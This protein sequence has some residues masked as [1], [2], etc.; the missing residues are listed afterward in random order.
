[1]PHGR[2]TGERDCSHAPRAR[3]LRIAALVTRRRQAIDAKRATDDAGETYSF[4]R[5]LLATGGRPRRLPDAPDEVIY[6]RTLDDYRRMADELNA[7]GARAKPMGF[8]VLYHNHGY[9]FAPVDGQVPAR[10]LFDRLDP[11]VV[12]LEMDL[13]WTVAASTAMPAA[14]AA[15][16][17]ASRA[18]AK[19]SFSTRSRPE[20]GAPG[21][22]R[23]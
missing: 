10:V 22:G 5:L 23:W 11:D 20:S 13:F 17:C 14:R 9:G 7:I 16:Y 19:P 18:S 15:R 3:A 21:G 8:K 4:D 1:M 2:A 6:F 12:A